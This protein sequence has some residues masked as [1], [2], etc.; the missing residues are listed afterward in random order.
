MKLIDDHWWEGYPLKSNE[1]TTTKIR[2]DLIINLDVT[3]IMHESI[4]SIRYCK[5]CGQESVNS[6]SPKY[7]CKEE[8]I[9]KILDT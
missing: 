6:E 7:G 8:C 1:K 9:R 4:K 2:D 5:V 3:F